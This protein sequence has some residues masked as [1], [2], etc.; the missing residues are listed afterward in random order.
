MQ[1][2][3]ALGYKMARNGLRWETRP[4]GYERVLGTTR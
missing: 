3:F 4:P 1:E 2:L